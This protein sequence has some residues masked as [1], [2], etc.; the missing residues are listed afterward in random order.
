VISGTP[1][2]EAWFTNQ[3]FGDGGT[4]AEANPEEVVYTDTDV[5]TLVYCY[6]VKAFDILGNEGPASN[7]AEVLANTILLW[8][9]TVW[10]QQGEIVRVPVNLGNARDLSIPSTAASW[11]S[12]N[13]IFS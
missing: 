3:S 6:R 7:T 11:N 8:L 5:E 10:G 1:P 2:L 12:L 9:P 4:S 13:S